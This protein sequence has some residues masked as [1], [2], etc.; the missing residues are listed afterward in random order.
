MEN[1]K[2]ND[3]LLLG[4]ILILTLAAGIFMLLNSTGTGVTAVVTVDGEEFGSYSLLQEREISISDT[5]VLV[6]KD[7]AADMVSADCP[8][9]V[10]VKHSPIAKTGET[11][12][13]LPN[14]VVVTIESVN[15]AQ[16]ADEGIDVIVK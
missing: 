13:C 5:N 3:L 8:D 2:R 15:G 10:C 7:G 9:Q 6:I 14:K 1:K 12:I 4:C 16:E 11:I